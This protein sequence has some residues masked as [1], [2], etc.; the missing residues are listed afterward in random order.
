MESGAPRFSPS[1]RGYAGWCT[2]WVAA[3]IGSAEEQQLLS[4][5]A[6][7]NPPTNDS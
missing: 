2:P 3:A 4:L 6:L 7:G 1:T 5:E